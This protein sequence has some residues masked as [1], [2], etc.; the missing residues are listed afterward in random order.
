MKIQTAKKIIKQTNQRTCVNKTAKRN[1][2]SDERS[3]DIASARVTYKTGNRIEPFK[4]PV[5]GLFHIGNRM[6][7][8]ELL[9]KLAKQT[10][11]ILHYEI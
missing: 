1:V 8:D 3:A 7:Y 5:C 10:K 6:V 2:F 11:P 4:C 9:A